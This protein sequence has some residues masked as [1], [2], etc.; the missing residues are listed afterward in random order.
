MIEELCPPQRV[1]PTSFFLL[2]RFFLR[3][4]GVMIRIND[5]RLF[6]EASCSLS[7][8]HSLVTWHFY[9]TKM[10]R[11]CPSRASLQSYALTRHVC[12]L[13][14]VCLFFG[15]C[16]SLNLCSKIVFLVLTQSYNDFYW[17]HFKVLAFGMQP[18][19]ACHGESKCFVLNLLL[20]SHFFHF[21]FFYR[22]EAT[23]FSENSA[24]EKAK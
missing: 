24:Q 19:S 6:H 3:V 5:T 2:L 14:V 4:D 16:L 11:L 7:C 1:M 17:V 9:K 23:T 12:V 10:L 15:P 20:M 8:P 21:H 13:V 18:W 22:L